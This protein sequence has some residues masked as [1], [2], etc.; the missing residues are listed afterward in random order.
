MYKGKSMCSL[1]R[2]IFSPQRLQVS[3][4]PLR[5]KPSA[6]ISKEKYIY[7]IA[8]DFLTFEGG[9]EKPNLKSVGKNFSTS[10]TLTLYLGQVV[11]WIVIKNLYLKATAKYDAVSKKMNS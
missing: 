10:N 7:M 5:F 8:E 1:N 11:K 6:I 2:E 9:E 4:K 3:G